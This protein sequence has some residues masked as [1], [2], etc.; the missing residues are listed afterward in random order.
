VGASDTLV[1][2]AD[3][4]RAWTDDAY[5]KRKEI[6]VRLGGTIRV[7]FDM[8]RSAVGAPGVLGKIYV[9]GVA[10]GTERSSGDT[11]YETFSEDISIS[12]FDLVQL[13]TN[14]NGGAGITGYVRNFRIYY[15]LSSLDQT[16]VNTD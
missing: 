1:A 11:T 3:T 12:P 4:E 6:I 16:T 8:K 9:N 13:Y 14:R 7:K 10:V 2:S 5:T 15:D